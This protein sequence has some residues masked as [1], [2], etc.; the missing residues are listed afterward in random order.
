MKSAT[1][2]GPGIDENQRKIISLVGLQLCQADIARKLG[3]SRAYVN[4]TVKRLETHSLI[5]RINTHPK[6]EGKRKYTLFYELSPELKARVKGERIAE[7][8]TSCRVHNL[9]LKCHIISQSAPVNTDKRTNYAKSWTMRGGPRHKFWFMGKAGMPSVTLDV[10][11]KTIVCYVDKKQTIVAR[12]P[13]EAKD[14]GWRAIYAALDKFI[15]LQS[16][17][18]VQVD[19]EHT[20]TV[21]GKPHGGFVGSESPVM[22][23]GVNDTELVD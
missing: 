17:F 9:R 7:P 21:I 23:E 22:L 4:Q 10:H 13:D 2:A 20:G 14:I 11:P 15:E 8:F 18:D 3:F 5:Q 16:R 12:T 6:K 19:V 1:S